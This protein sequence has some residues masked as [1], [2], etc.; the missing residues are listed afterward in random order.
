LIAKLGLTRSTSI[1]FVTVAAGIILRSTSGFP[2]LLAGTIVLGAGIALG[3]ALF[4]L[5]SRH[6]FP[7]NF[8]AA[9]SWVTASMNVSAFV[10]NATVYPLSLLWSWRVALLIWLALPVMGLLLQRLAIAKENI[11]KPE[12]APATAQDDLVTTKSVRAWKL[13]LA[14]LLVIVFAAQSSC[15]YVM[16]AWLPQIFG[17]IGLDATQSGLAAA[18]FQ[19]LGL[20][21]AVLTPWSVKHLNYAW[22]FAWVAA[23]WFALPFTLLV[24][25]QFWW[26][27]LIFSGV[28][29]SIT[30]NLV[31]GVINVYAA[32][33]VQVRQISS[34]VQMCGYAIA[35]CMPTIVGLLFQHFQTW[36][37]TQILAISL[38]ILMLI[39]SQIALK[40]VKRR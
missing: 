15:Y 22:T 10:A 37:I 5:L 2:V 19:V 23:G 4:P 24:I 27:A 35:G 6:Y 38:I 1:F 20:F 16:T 39:C 30:Y 7:D 18:T 33:Q 17:A 14:W 29:Q 13:P 9:V 36:N 8:V 40:M 3:N 31:F 25:P 12:L 11:P 28:S 26:I 21:G 32:D 34:F